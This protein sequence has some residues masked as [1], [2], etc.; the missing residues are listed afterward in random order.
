MPGTGHGGSGQRAGGP[1]AMRVLG[2]PLVA[3]LC[4][5][6][7]FAVRDEDRVE[8]EAFLATRL[9]GDPALEDARAAKLRAL[10]RQ[11]D[12]LADVA[13][14]S[15]SGSTPSSASST[16]STCAPPAHLA[17]FRPGAP[18]SR[19]TSIPESSP[20]PR[21]CRADPRARNGPS[22]ARSRSRSRLPRGNSSASRS[23][24]SQPGSA[25]RSSASLCSFWEARRAFSSG[26]HRF[27]GCGLGPLD[28]LDP[29]RRQ[30]EQRVE[31]VT[32]QGARSAVAC[33]SIRRPSPAM[34]TLTSTSAAESS[35]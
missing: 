7:L 18:P 19:A 21:V 25:L 12:E 9:F 27:H 14:A 35:M 8:A 23:S 24:S 4:D 28:L 17:D 15:A 34:T 30:V 3:E 6:A 1:G 20:S 13:R 10:G 31:L 33:T 26:T 32:G 2:L 29:A 11:R 16:R 22:P 5:G